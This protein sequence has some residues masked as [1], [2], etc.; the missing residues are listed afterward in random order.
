MNFQDNKNLAQVAVQMRKQKLTLAVAESCTSGLLQ[1]VFSQA[2]NSMAFFQGGLTAY[3]EG[4]KAKQLNINP[5]FAEECNSVSK[6]IA[7]KMAL[8]ISRKFNA[9]LGISITGYA[10]PIPEEGINNSFAYISI[11]KEGKTVLSRKIMGEK[12][13]S[14]AENQEIYAIKIIDA[15][16]EVLT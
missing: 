1:T 9:E 15:L 4:Q 2:E 16:L 3:N 14:L 13:K 11:A 7:E 5:I 10:E 6:D 12:N 8:E